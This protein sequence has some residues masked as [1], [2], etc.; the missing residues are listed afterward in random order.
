MTTQDI[1]FMQQALRLARFGWG[2]VAPNPAVGCV[3]VDAA[4]HV[5]GTGWTQNTGRPHA[6]TVALAEAGKR[7]RG[8]TAY[9]TLEPCAHTGKTP[10]CAQA[11]IEAGIARVVYA[12]G[13]PDARVNG[14]GAAMLAAAGIQVETGLCAAQA[15][16]DQR[17]FLLSQ[18]DKRA[19]VT[20]KIAISAD[21]FMRTPE[22]QSPW[23]TGVLARQKGHMLRAQHDAI[24]TGAGTLAADDPS[25]D[26]RLPGLA[27]ASP[28]P[29]MMSRGGKISPK[30][31]LAQRAKHEAV[32]LYTQTD[33]DFAGETCVVK[34]LTP[35]AVLADLAARGIT[36]VLLECGP[37][38]A[39]AF[40]QARCLDEV[41][42]FIS[43]KP[44]DLGGKSDISTLMS[45]EGLDLTQFSEG[46]TQQFGQ[47]TY[48]HYTRHANWQEGASA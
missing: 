4:G 44:V 21:G 20:L 40:A 28:L 37:K 41:A 33:S 5:V 12:I 48:I 6:E 18:S 43:S 7:A 32:L 29:V 46:D 31:K 39:L 30:C 45:P 13:D 9:V 10:P 35:E 8:G 14:A 38:L 15:E 17:G 24:I 34:Q 42:V 16:T 1:H 27:D 2:Q 11:L 22:G 36:R 19:M 3:V 47:D 25:L 23:I 26:C